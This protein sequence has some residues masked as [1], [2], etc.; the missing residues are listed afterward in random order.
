MFQLFQKRN[1][2][3]KA[4][5]QSASPCVFIV[6][7]GETFLIRAL[8]GSH[9][10]GEL[11]LVQTVPSVCRLIPLNNKYSGASWNGVE[12]PG[13]SIT[14]WTSAFGSPASRLPRQMSKTGIKRRSRDRFWICRIGNPQDR[15]V[16][17]RLSFTPFFTAKERGMLC[18]SRVVT[19]ECIY[20]TG[21]KSF[22]QA[23]FPL[24]R[25]EPF[26]WPERDFRI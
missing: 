13:R 3:K 7:W 23:W 4:A 20:L 11:K 19:I 22:L 16:P 9:P 6:Q 12:N 15:L 18:F 1:E 14:H 5:R 17:G 2:P 26:F 8:H 24:M 10:S 25:D 21:I